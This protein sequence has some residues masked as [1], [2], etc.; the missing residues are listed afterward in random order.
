MPDCKPD[1]IQAKEFSRLKNK[2]PPLFNII[3]ALH[4]KSKINWLLFLIEIAS[5]SLLM[6]N[7]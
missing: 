7:L 3:V 5:N 1:T 4:I 6:H 2:K